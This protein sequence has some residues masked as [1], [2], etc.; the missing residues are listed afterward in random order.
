MEKL[1]DKLVKKYHTN[2]PFKIAAELNIS[3]IKKDLGNIRGFYKKILKRKYI[4]ININLSN[5][6]RKIVCG[7]ELGHAILHNQKEL[8]FMLKHTKIIKK[9]KLEEEANRFAILLL[10]KDTCEDICIE[11]KYINIQNWI[12]KNFYK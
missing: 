12:D 8:N 3:I 7:H 10:F 1:I 9:N 11:E 6:E 5:I 4:F 2:D